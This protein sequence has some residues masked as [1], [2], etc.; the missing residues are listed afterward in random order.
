MPNDLE[1]MAAH[2]ERVMLETW[3]GT[4]V[5]WVQPEGERVEH[6][7]DH[8]PAGKRQEKEK[9]K[10]RSGSLME[11]QKGRQR[12]SWKKMFPALC[13]PASQL[14]PPACSSWSLLILLG[15]TKHDLLTRRP[16]SSCY[17]STELRGTKITS[18]CT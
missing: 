15:S 3:L 4:P 11:N 5:A 12:G 7:Q 18:L 1:L 13:A 6:R 10:C 8:G 2:Q 14:P 9:T 17:S 16:A